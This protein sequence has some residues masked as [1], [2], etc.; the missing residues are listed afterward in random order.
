MSRSLRLLTY[1]TQMR[2]W[3]MEVLAQGNP[4]PVDSTEQRAKT[5]SRRIL[6]SSE[7]Y[8]VICLNEVFDE[9]AREVFQNELGASYP[10]IVLKADVDNLGLQIGLV[11]GG[12]LG[13]PRCS[14]S[15]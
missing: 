14:R 12:A 7:Q 2:S 11:A 15:R 6:E 5:I 10:N 8:D 3:G 1:N 4:F 9:D 13:V